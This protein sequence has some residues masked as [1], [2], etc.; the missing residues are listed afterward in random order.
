MAGGR[1]GRVQLLLALGD[2]GGVGRVE[3]TL[4]RAGDLVRRLGREQLA[5]P[6]LGHVRVA[7]LPQH[8]S[9]PAQLPGQGVDHLGVEQR[10]EARQ[11]RP[12]PAA[13]DPGVVHALLGVA[14]PDLVHLPV[15]LGD[16][17]RHPLVDDRTRSHVRRQPGRDVV[18]PRHRPP[19]RGAGWPPGIGA[20]GSYGVRV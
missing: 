5:E 2:P 1:Q 14:D 11:R 8:P 18:G 16:L 6:L 12:Q 9:Q 19:L 20:S 10:T 13:G 17:Q 7:R 4:H 3:P 15:Q